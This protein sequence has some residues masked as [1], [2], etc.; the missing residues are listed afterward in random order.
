MLTR[1]LAPNDVIDYFDFLAGFARCTF[2]TSPDAD[3]I[4][5]IGEF[6]GHLGIVDAAGYRRNFAVTIGATVY[7]PCEPGAE[8][9]DAWPL[10]IQTETGGHECVHVRQFTGRYAEAWRIPRTTAAVRAALRQGGGF[11]L[12]YL[13]NEESRASYELEA[14]A[15]QSEIRY[16][17]FGVVYPSD[18]LFEGLQHSYACSRASAEFARR[19]MR[20][21][22]KTIL[23]NR[24]SDPVTLATVGFF[25]E[26]G[27]LAA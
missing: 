27:L 10:G 3:E 21:R 22:E 25:Q 12:D 2:R 26:R 4:A 1:P 24:Y 18:Q 13:T 14:Y 15:C 11:M 5:L 9:P 17:L 16:Q 6:L 20:M 19:G 7:L 23:R 8:G